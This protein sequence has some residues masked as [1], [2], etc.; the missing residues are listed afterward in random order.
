MNKKESSGAVL[1]EWKMVHDH[2]LREK[3]TFKYSFQARNSVIL[4]LFIHIGQYIQQSE[5]AEQ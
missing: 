5:A 3:K 4:H 1:L 2:G